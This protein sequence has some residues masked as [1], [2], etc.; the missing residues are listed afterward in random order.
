M[1]LPAWAWVCRMSTGMQHEHGH[2]HLFNLAL[3]LKT[4]SF[5]PVCLPK[6]LKTTRNSAISKTAL[7]FSFA[8]TALR[9]A[10]HLR[11]TRKLIENFEYLGKFEKYFRKY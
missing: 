2:E 9:Y 4:Q 6:M 11:R 8:A 1:A 10:T 3:L 7:S 5:T